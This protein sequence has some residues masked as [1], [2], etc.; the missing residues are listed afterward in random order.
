MGVPEPDV[1]EQ[2]LRAEVVRLVCG[3]KKCPPSDLGGRA[4]F[5]SA[6]AFDSLDLVELATRLDSAYGVEIGAEPD[7]LAALNS[8]DKLT[9]LIGQRRK[10]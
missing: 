10:R 1:P 4:D 5:A 8:L 7:D 3:I 9:S 2:E 6:L